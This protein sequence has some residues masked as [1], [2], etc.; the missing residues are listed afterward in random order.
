MLIRRRQVVDR[1]FFRP[2]TPDSR[3]APPLGPT[4][5]E[6]GAARVSRFDVASPQDLAS[7]DFRL[8][9]APCLLRVRHVHKGLV[10]APNTASM[11]SWWRGGA[12]PRCH[13][14]L[15]GAA[16]SVACAPR[17]S[18]AVCVC[19]SRSERTVRSSVPRPIVR[20]AF[21]SALS[22]E[23]QIL[24]CHHMRTHRERAR[25]G[26]RRPERT[27]AR[28]SRPGRPAA[29]VGAGAGATHTN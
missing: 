2:G 21:A 20:R 15:G 18:R 22:R 5:T 10:R 29:P 7:A 3:L 12:E 13:F 28:A 6:L 11:A 1:T 26:R 17:S 16:V 4:G 9:C 14:A 24:L 25:L 19:V 8:L 27:R 23:R